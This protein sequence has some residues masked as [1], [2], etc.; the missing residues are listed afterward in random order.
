MQ[1]V[2]G[3]TRTAPF[4]MLERFPPAR[5]SRAAFVISSGDALTLLESGSFDMEIS[6]RLNSQ[7]VMV[8]YGP[9]LHARRTGTHSGRQNPNALV[10]YELSA[11]TSS[12]KLG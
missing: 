4:L 11:P 3:F 7:H 12:S 10:P 8:A 1:R 9:T 5:D 2:P 6:Y